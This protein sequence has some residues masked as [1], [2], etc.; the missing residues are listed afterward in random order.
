LTKWL[1]LLKARDCKITL[2]PLNE[3]LSMMPGFYL[4]EDVLE[5]RKSYC[6]PRTAEAGTEDREEM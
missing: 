3:K 1:Q 5:N 6:F 2:E 4:Q